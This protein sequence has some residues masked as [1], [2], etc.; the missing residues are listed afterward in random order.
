MK[1]GRSAG[2]A[3]PTSPDDL[4]PRN[5]ASGSGLGLALEPEYGDQLLL[6][7]VGPAAIR[8]V[9]GVAGGSDVAVEDLPHEVRG[10]GGV[11]LAG[12]GNFDEQIYGV[13]RGLLNRVL[14]QVGG[15]QKDAAQQLGLTYDRFRHLLRKHQIIG[16]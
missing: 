9:E 7:G 10:E 14:E 15:S 2:P 12:T 5:P 13:E 16:K 1:G 11:A 8:S 6:K 3:E 4:M